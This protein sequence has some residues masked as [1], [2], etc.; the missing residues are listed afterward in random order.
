MGGSTLYIESVVSER[1][2]ES[3]GGLHITGQLGDVMKESTSLALT[4]A[5]GAPHAHSGQSA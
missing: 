4:V 1:N 3:G 2:K 5:K